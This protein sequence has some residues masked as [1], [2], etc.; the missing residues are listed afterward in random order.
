MENRHT[1]RKA[2]SVEHCYWFKAKP[3]SS[4]VVRRSIVSLPACPFVDHFPLPIPSTPLHY[5]L[6]L[7]YN[8]ITRTILFLLFRELIIK[9][10]KNSSILPINL[11]EWN[12][13]VDFQP[14][15]NCGVELDWHSKYFGF[16]PTLQNMPHET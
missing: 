13:G 7:G 10:W 12:F 3:E 14:N 5:N 16:A 9:H 15:I 1:N 2:G 11:L 4:L 6:N 8:I